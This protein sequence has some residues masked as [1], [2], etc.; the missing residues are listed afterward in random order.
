MKNLYLQSCFEF[1]HIYLVPHTFIK[2]PE[3]LHYPQLSLLHEIDDSLH[4]VDSLIWKAN[5][6]YANEYDNT[7]DI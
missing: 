4:G 6:Q 5:V 7:V 3:E 1:L 2:A